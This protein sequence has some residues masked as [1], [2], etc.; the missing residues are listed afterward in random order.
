MDQRYIADDSYI[1]RK[2]ESH[3]I[4]SDIINNIILIISNIRNSDR[5]KY[6]NVEYL[7]VSCYSLICNNMDINTDHIKLVEISMIKSTDHNNSC[8]ALVRYANYVL[9][10]YQHSTF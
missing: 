9:K 6:L 7:T 5:Y 10:S 2:L 3:N 4:S 8:D 1:N